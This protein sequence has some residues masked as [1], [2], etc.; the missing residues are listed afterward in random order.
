VFPASATSKSA[1]VL[2]TAVSSDEL[3]MTAIPSRER[4]LELESS[5]ARER[6]LE[7]ER[8]RERN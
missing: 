8:E 5:R 3:S 1:G 7:K 6:E 2:E 4:D